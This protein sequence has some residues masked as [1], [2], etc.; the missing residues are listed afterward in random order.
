[1]VGIKD[2]QV[3]IAINNDPK[4]PIFQEVDFG[5]VGDLRKI[6]PL[7]IQELGGEL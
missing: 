3:A 2:A 7:L 5:I 4:A 6:V 1:M